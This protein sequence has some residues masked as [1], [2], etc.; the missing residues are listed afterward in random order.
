MKTLRRIS[1]LLAARSLVRTTALLMACGGLALHA[2]NALDSAPGAPTAT[3]T[4]DPSNPTPPPPAAP[5][6]APQLTAPSEADGPSLLTNSDFSIVGK[7]ADFPADWGHGAPNVT[8]ETENGFHF[9]RLVQTEP[10]KMLMAYREMPIPPGTK[11]LKITIRFRT[12]KIVHGATNW[13]DARAIFH[14]LGADKKQIK[15]EPG[16]IVFKGN[17]WTE[18]SV[19]CVVPEGAVT[20]QLMP[21]IFMAKSGTLDLAEVR[22]TALDDTAVESIATANAAKNKKAADRAAIISEQEKLPAKTSELKVLGNKLVTADG[23]EVWLQGVNVVPL[24]WSPNGEN[25]IPWSIY[26]AT[27]DWHAN[28]I[29]LPVMDS[30]WFGRGRGTE[31]AND[32]EAYRAIVD[33]AVKIAAANGAYIVLDLHRF[34][35]PDDS[36]VEFWKDAAARYKDNP[37]VLFDL[38]NEPH[39]TSWEVWQKGGPIELK[40]KDGSKK[41]VQGVG[42]QAL[43]DAVRSTGAKNIVVCGGLAYAYDLTGI[44]KGFAL[45]DKGGNG[46][47]YATHFYNWHKGW[48]EHFMAVAEKYPILIGETGADVNKMGFIPL[49]DQEDPSTWVPDAIGFIQKNKLNWT[50]WSFNTG[51]TPAMLIKADEITPNSYWGQPVKE[52][53]AGKQYDMQK[54]R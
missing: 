38:F 13:K 22:V 6:A 9:L 37:A 28:V 17:T 48:R 3:L 21:S 33:Q 26:V 31:T 32:K 19:S 18:K 25:G 16:A 39:G 51:A 5:P 30:F 24:G 36:C 8:W 49:K 35:T 40:E 14:F 42:M 15:P 41:T 1:S 12:D 54:E 7:N 44:T 52:A 53:L 11:G 47:M 34:L 45:D 10:D 43:I 27:H 46:I 29:R 23:K 20:L 50:A 2:Q 4:N